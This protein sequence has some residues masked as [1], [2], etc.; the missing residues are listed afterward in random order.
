MGTRPEGGN[1]LPDH[2]KDEQ[3]HDNR[4]DLGAIEVAGQGKQDRDDPSDQPHNQAQRL[5]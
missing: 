4:Q 3:D 1:A 2:T 5:R